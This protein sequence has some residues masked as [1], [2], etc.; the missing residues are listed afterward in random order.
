MKIKMLRAII[1]IIK[2]KNNNSN[3]NENTKKQ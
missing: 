3:G 1:R 2:N